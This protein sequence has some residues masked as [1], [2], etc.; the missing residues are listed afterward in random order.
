MTNGAQ[1]TP[2]LDLADISEAFTEARAR[3]D[4]AFRHRAMRRQ[5]PQIAVEAG[6]R[7]ACAS[8][9]LDGQAYELDDVRAGTALNP[10]VQSAL[11]VTQALDELSVTWQKAPRQALARLHVLA[12]RG[13]VADE[14]L[15]RPE[16]GAQ[17]RLDLL[18]DL[19]TSKR[20]DTLL[21][22]AVVHGDLLAAK[23]FGAV[24]GLVARAAARLVLISGGLDPR[25]LLPVDVG[26]RDREPEY[27]GASATFVTGTPDGLRS[28]LKHYAAAVIRAAEET[29]AISDSLMSQG[30]SS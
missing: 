12:G 28:W 19:V 3:V 8:A 7:D 5:G 13:I 16:P 22:A 17:P 26:H 29:E 23:P 14:E 9:A 30:E 2:L 18:A 10:V 20:E 21:L 25:G 6:L 4:A 27:R 15:G 11:R 24:N 1:L